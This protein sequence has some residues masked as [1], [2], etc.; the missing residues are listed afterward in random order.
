MVATGVGLFVAMVET[1]LPGTLQSDAFLQVTS[2]TIYSNTKTS[3]LTLVV[4]QVQA[5][6]WDSHKH[7]H[8]YEY[9]KLAK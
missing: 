7:T 6:L 1:G 3:G 2:N 8:L 9:R 4:E 5:F